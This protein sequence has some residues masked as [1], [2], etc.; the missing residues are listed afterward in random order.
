[1]P[2]PNDY[3]DL[4]FDKSQSVERQENNLG[5]SGEYGYDRRPA[6]FE[7]PTPTSGYPNVFGYGADA[8]DRQFSQD[9]EG[10]PIR[11]MEQTRA[12]IQAHGDLN[13]AYGLCQ[14]VQDLGTHCW[15]RDSL[16]EPSER[17]PGNAEPQQD[18]KTPFRR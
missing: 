15:L 2:T 12:S 1:M 3:S 17:E 10:D 4:R 9:K 16:A 13:E 18:V 7:T 6:D 14:P 8:G 5:V 11:L